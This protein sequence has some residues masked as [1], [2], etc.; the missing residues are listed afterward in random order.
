MADARPR[1]SVVIPTYNGAAL[2][3]ACLD[4]LLAHPPT[5]C[6]WSL[7]VVD[8]ASPEDPGP[9]L[10]GYERDATIVR[11]EF[12]RGFAGACNAGARAAESD[13]VVFLNNDTLP[14]EGWLDALVAAAA[15]D[16]E[17][18]AVGA[19]LL[20]PD[21]RVQHAGVAIHA[22]GLPF[23]LYSGFEGGHPAINR[24][25]DVVA[26]TAACM[27][28]RR[29]VFDE[30][31]GFDEEYRN[32]YEDIDLCLRLAEHGGKVRYCHRSLVI[33]LESVT[34][35]PDGVPVDTAIS[36]AIYQ[37]RWR[38]RVVPDDIGHYAR[39]GLIRSTF[40]PYCPVELSVDPQLGVI[41]RTDEQLD[42]IERLLA[43][44]A[45]QVIELQGARTRREVR[46][47]DASPRPLLEPS[48]PR[49]PERV[50]EG[51]EHVLGGGGRLVSV[52]M[53][54]KNGGRYLRETI[55]AVL[56]QSVSARVEI[57]AIDSGSGDDTLALLEQF[58]A[59][60]WRIR[61]SDFD[62][63][64]TRNLLAERAAGDVLVF[65]NQIACP[66]GEHW[67]EPLLSA[68][69]GDPQVAAACS[70]LVP[71]PDADP[72]TRRDGLRD[73]CGST[74][75]RRIEIGVLSEYE[76][77]DAEQ[78]RRFLNFHT[79]STAVR[80]DAIRRTPFRSVRA[81]GEDLLWAREVVESG[82]ALIH[83]PA[84]EVH[85]SHPYTYGELLGRNVDDGVANHDIVG[86]V[87][88]DA[89]IVPRIRAQ[90]ADDWAY[91][92]DE[93]GLTGDELEH[94]KI[95][96]ALRRAS[97]TVGQ[98]VGANYETLPGGVA[99]RFSNVAQVRAGRTPAAGE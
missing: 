28:V 82:W 63:G 80:A 59:R 56:S 5:T 73:L 12:N 95:E 31:G 6:E 3:A 99:A 74:E 96:A 92:R 20:F 33:H 77:M 68:L 98:W 35:F 91:L 88:H 58:G 62:H 49:E 37:R 21:G 43:A 57:V 32:A 55:A 52:L 42:D 81:L 46:S 29:D 16:P 75:R 71:R 40:E 48:P 1:C 65:L 34:R 89:E 45:R 18:A 30:I 9:M 94:W 26:V 19:K 15:A 70:R 54:V 2:T 53:P 87:V 11:L 64:L 4:A 7:I 36:D 83:E 50:Y 22:N 66:I 13:Y 67:L 25:R 47:L 24:D 76:T 38:S 85:H 78:R 93:L 14:A 60:T 44:R 72:L 84:S 69:D 23:H 90:V 8:D 97:Q 39:D 51:R 17:V 27:L 86:R 79:V 41:R 61:P 10:A